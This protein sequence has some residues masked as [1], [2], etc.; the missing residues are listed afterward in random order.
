M[1]SRSI[2]RCSHH[3][4]GLTTDGILGDN[5]SPGCAL[6]SSSSLL[7]HD[8]DDVVVPCSCMSVQDTFH[9]LQVY[10]SLVTTIEVYKLFATAIL[11]HSRPFMTSL[12]TCVVTPKRNVLNGMSG[13][14]QKIIEKMKLLVL[15]YRRDNTT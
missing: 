2:S 5:H 13:I 7:I 3:H 6:V 1:P 9:R 10:N 11:F 15:H 12:L 4:C 14:Y 8:D